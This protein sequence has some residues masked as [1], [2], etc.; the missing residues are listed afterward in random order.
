MRP[1]REGGSIRVDF[2]GEWTA[3][4]ERNEITTTRRGHHE[5]PSE[6]IRAIAYRI[7]V[8]CGGHPVVGHDANAET[9]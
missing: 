3:T 1:I 6:Q 9:E 8:N 7:A 5:R 4:I 2:D